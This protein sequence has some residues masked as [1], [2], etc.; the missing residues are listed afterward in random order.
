MV[1]TI[2]FDMDGVLVDS[3]EAWYQSFNEVKKIS[4]EDFDNFFWGRD[5]QVNLKTL[6]IGKEK[7]CR[8]VFPKHLES[9]EVFPDVKK[10]LEKRKEK[11]AVVTN[12]I[13]ICAKQILKKAELTKLFQGIFTSDMA[14]EGKPNPE[15]LLKACQKLNRNVSQTVM[16]G[17][18]ISD[19]DAARS[20][21]MLSIGLRVQG[22]YSIETLSELNELLTR[23]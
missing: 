6:G 14:N 8:Q 12:T 18:T 5:L 20:A 21:G 3:K 7:F 15:L 10:I 16:V 17:D 11:M 2:L 23:I 1:E 9:I 19:M 4:R 13:G 22:D